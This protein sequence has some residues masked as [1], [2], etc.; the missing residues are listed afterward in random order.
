MTKSLLLNLT[1]LKLISLAW[2]CMED[3]EFYI[4]YDADVVNVGL[5]LAMFKPIEYLLEYISKRKIK[6]AV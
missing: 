3:I 6:N 5:S 1:V 4:A 2:S